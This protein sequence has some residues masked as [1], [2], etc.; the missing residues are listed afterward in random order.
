[1]CR[2]RFCSAESLTQS[3]AVEMEGSLDRR[4]DA[5]HRYVAAKVSH[6]ALCQLEL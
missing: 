2:V 3:E 6:P 5:R 4:L 1:M